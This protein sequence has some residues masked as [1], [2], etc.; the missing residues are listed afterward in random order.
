M[1][2]PTEQRPQS[3]DLIPVQ[4]YNQAQAN[5]IKAAVGLA[6]QIHGILT[7]KLEE[8]NTQRQIR[9][10]KEK[11]LEDQIIAQTEEFKS[12]ADE[13]QELEKRRAAQPDPNTFER[14][15]KHPMIRLFFDK[16]L[17]DDK[18]TYV[19]FVQQHGHLADHPDFPDGCRSIYSEDMS[20]D[21]QHLK[22]PE[23]CGEYPLLPEHIRMSKEAVVSGKMRD[24]KEKLDASKLPDEGV[25]PEAQIY[26]PNFGLSAADS[27][28]VVSSKMQDKASRRP[29]DR[30][31][32]HDV[33]ALSTSSLPAQSL[34]VQNL[35]NAI[36]STFENCKPVIKLLGDQILREK[37]RIIHLEGE[38]AEQKKVHEARVEVLRMRLKKMEDTL[39]DVDD[40][41]HNEYLPRAQFFG[42]SYGEY[43]D[44]CQKVF[45]PFGHH[46]HSGSVVKNPAITFESKP[47]RGF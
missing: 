9:L 4:S 6:S 41:M 11:I 10:E 8:L 24:K 39:N 35:T 46:T 18:K 28:Q 34:A 29:K 33:Q 45:G 44:S 22:L 30:G 1:T 3:S 23:G 25:K 13:A 15:A 5:Y 17:E 40:F 19:K 26:N 20:S 31:A 36:L 37:R 47:Y 32:K 21:L 38:T 27:G 7:Q 2:N 16:D 43:R 14:K 12:I 42:C